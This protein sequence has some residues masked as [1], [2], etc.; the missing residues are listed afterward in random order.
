[1]LCQLFIQLLLASTAVLGKPTP[2]RHGNL[3][4]TKRKA[5]ASPLNGLQEP[6]TLSPSSQLKFVTVGVGHQNYSC[7]SPDQAPV[8]IGATAT[9]F[10]V[11]K[12]LQANGALISSL[13]GWALSV[14]GLQQDI[15]SSRTDSSSDQA[16]FTI[17]S[18]V[19]ALAQDRLGYH[20]FDAGAS[21]NFILEK[22]GVSFVLV[23][24]KLGDVSAPAASTATSSG[25][26][27]IDWLLLGD[28]GQGRSIGLSY[29]YRIE[30]AGGAP[31]A[32]CA[33]VP[34]GGVIRV[35]YAA[36]YWFYAPN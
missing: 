10:D 12:Y 15:K 14:S 32:T 31:P 23:G 4:W 34:S 1:M 9:L 24:K 28:N 20:V 5:L 6:S 33:G 35:P 3:D 36:E 17:G 13:P 21:P 7:A 8:S 18:N 2:K 29:V 22:G 19:P 11:E 27:A 16:D 26:K 30:T 25:V